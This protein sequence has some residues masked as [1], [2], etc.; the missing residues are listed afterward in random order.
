MPRLNCIGVL[1]VDALSGP[2]AEYP[3]PRVRTQVTTPRVTF[4]PGGGA[5]NTPAALGRM[6][7]PVGVFSKV[8]DD[9]NGAF[10]LREMASVGVDVSGIRVSAEDTTP[11]TFVGIHESGDRTFIHTPG[12]N[13]TLCAEDFDPDALFA[14]D[15]LLYQDLWVKPRLDGAPAAEILAEAQRRGIVTLLDECWGLGPNRD[16]F[17]LLLP[18]C[19]FVLP[20]LDD[21]RAI[22]PGSSDEEIARRLLDLGAGTVALKMGAEGAL[23][24]HGDERNRVAALPVQV[25]DTTGAGDCWDAGFIAGLMS[26]EDLEISARLG[27]ACAAFCIEAVGGA[28][29]VPGYGEVKM[30]AGVG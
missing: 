7:L 10:L 16:T 26:G 17:E 23:L 29:G 2:L 27:A 6:G 20:S 28:A 9:P 24:A 18:H 21:M 19:D 12:A 15:Y 22:Y 14:C 4:L 8:G 1:V 13:L 5:A 30:R 25:A 3:I 11:F